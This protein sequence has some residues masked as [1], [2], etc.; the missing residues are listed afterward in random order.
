MIAAMINGNPEPDDIRKY[1]WALR[2]AQRDI[3]LRP[4]LFTHFYNELGGDWFHGPDG[5]L[6]DRAWPGSEGART[7]R[8]DWRSLRNRACMWTTA[9]SRMT[10][11]H[12]F[13]PSI[14]STRG[15]SW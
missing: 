9:G 8:K 5:H 6:I 7:C 15:S 10:C 12:S 3:D 13:A 14:A 1:F 2:R 4:D 11:G